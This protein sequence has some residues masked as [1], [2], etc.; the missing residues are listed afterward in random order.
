MPIKETPIAVVGVIVNG[1]PLV[2]IRIGEALMLVL[3]A[4]DALRFAISIAETCADIS[5][6]I[7]ASADDAQRAIDK[8]KRKAS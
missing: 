4:S 1:C 2:E 5:K 6:S 7:K 8:A 3:P